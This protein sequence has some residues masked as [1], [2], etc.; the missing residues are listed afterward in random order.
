MS[1]QPSAVSRRPFMPS[2]L[3]AF[4][5]SAVAFCP[6]CQSPQPEPSKGPEPILGR[7]HAE[8]PKPETID[9]AKVPERDDIVGVY[10]FWLPVPWLTDS[11]GRIIGFQVRVYFQSAATGKGVFVPGSIYVWLREIEPDPES[12]IRRRDLHLWELD[13]D[14][15]YG[16]RVTMEAVLGYSYGFFLQWPENLDL[17]GREIEVQFGYERRDGTLI[18]DRA[19]PMRVPAPSDLRHSRPRSEPR[20]PASAPRRPATPGSE[21]SGRRTENLLPAPRSLL[22]AATVEPQ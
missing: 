18:R 1:R 6:G 16:Y 20:A 12:G 21:E 5:L 14:A 17:E 15:A 19:H 2:C 8:A 11:V 22:P 10:R 13:R 3:R 7:S 4:V 9:V